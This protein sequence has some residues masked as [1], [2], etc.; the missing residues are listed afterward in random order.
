MA[1]ESCLWAGCWLL[2]CELGRRSFCW[3][4][5]LHAALLSGQGCSWGNSGGAWEGATEEQLHMTSKE[6]CPQGQTSTGWT[7]G[8]PHWDPKLASVISPCTPVASILCQSCLFVPFFL[9]LDAGGVGG[10][11]KPYPSGF[12]FVLFLFDFGCSLPWLALAGGSSGGPAPGHKV[13]LF[14]WEP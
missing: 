3:K 2:D 6:L 14:S 1:G 13:F 12:Q 4:G 10:M 9:Q 8:F 7:R 11:T 5:R